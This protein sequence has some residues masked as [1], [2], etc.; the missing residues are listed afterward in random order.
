MSK[1]LLYVERAKKNLN[2]THR[3]KG[4]IQAGWEPYLIDIAN[5]RPDL[6]MKQAKMLDP[7]AVFISV[8]ASSCLEELEALLPKAYIFLFLGD[9]YGP[10]FRYVASLVPHFDCL[11]VSNNDTRIHNYFLSRGVKRVEEHQCATDTIHYKD[12]G[13]EPDKD[14]V[15]AGNVV[16]RTKDY[17]FRREM[18]TELVDKG[19]LGAFGAGWNERARP[20]SLLQYPKMMTR[21]KIQ[22]VINGFGFLRNCYS[23]RT[24]NAL[25]MGRPVLHYRTR[26][27]ER[28]FRDG[29]DLAFFS[30][31]DELYLKM[32]W[33]LDNPDEAKAIGQRGRR[34]V[35]KWHT[36][37]NRGEELLELLG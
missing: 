24:W 36:Y 33:L 16:R 26:N 19:V 6:I 17:A 28:Y 32:R 4:F 31:R 12:N 13:T 27:A 5:V 25:A 35:E 3:L 9:I 29:F 1:R 22:L 8:A 11:L 21:G 15:F 30:S 20:C 34:L 37:K 23:N 10:S 18:V 7:H 14:L 2:A